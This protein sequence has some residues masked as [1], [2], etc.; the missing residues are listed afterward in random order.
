VHKRLWA[1]CSVIAT[2]SSGNIHFRPPDAVSGF[3]GTM[4][5]METRQ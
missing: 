5:R 3:E 1:G 2:W 4:H